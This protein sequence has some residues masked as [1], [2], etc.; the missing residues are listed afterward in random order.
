MTD[1]PVLFRETLQSVYGPLDWLPEPDGNIHRFRVP[2]DKAGSLNGWYVLYLDG[3]A[4]GAFGSWKTGGAMSWC[5]REPVDAREAE[6]V[7]ERIEHAR[8][9]REA[10][11]QR[12]QKN[13]AEW[14]CRWWNQARRADPDHAYLVAKG[15]RGHGLRQRGDELLVP[16]YANGQLVNLQRIDPHGG[17]RF[18]AGGKVSASY[19]TFST[20]TPDRPLY[21]CEGWATGAT[22]HEDGGHTVAA[23]MNAGNL[24]PVALALRAK[25]PQQKIIIAGDDDRQTRGNP[26][27]VAAIAAALAI[28]AQVVF[29]DWPAGASLE[30]S[31]F[32][33][34][35]MLGAADG[36]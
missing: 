18:L 34:L 20:V 3:I 16:L 22:L 30:L 33:D 31:D 13:A 8:R 35:K 6:Q 11:R 5:S 27:R 14:A 9:Q 19:S 4:S 12:R 2:D 23:A 25:Y 15:V 17:K 10:E 7:R 1:A 26:G 29:P 32:N 21:V 28:D 24:K 36:H